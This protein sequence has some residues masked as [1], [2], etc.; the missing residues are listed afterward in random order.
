MAEKAK[1]KA[2]RS[3]PSVSLSPEEL[4]AMKERTREL[5]AEK[6]GGKDKAAAAAADVAEKIAAMP[7]AEAGIAKRIHDL[8]VAAGLKPRT[9]YGMPAYTSNEK[10]IVFF[11]AASKFKTRYSTVGFQEDAKLDEGVFWPTTFAI[12][13]MTKAAEVELAALIARALR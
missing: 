2:A 13:K 6:R 3:K 8:A 12:T 11:Q 4:E 5:K 10:V 9:W 1:T 7:E